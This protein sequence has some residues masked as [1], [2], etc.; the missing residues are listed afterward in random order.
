MIRSTGTPE[1]AGVLPRTLDVLFNSIPP[2]LQA[3]KFV[4]KPD[5]LNGYDVRLTEDAMIDRQVRCN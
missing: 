5:E 3:M 4:F 2:N 1:D